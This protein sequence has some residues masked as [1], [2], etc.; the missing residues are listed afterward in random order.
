MK[1]MTRGLVILLALPLLSACH[2]AK[3]STV[4]EKRSYTNR[5][6]SEALRD[7]YKAD[8]GTRARITRAA[9]YAVID[10]IES[11][12]FLVGTGRGYGVA[13]NN[14]TGRRTYMRKGSLGAG[15]GMG[16]KNIR[17]VYVFHTEKALGDFIERGL[18]VGAG[19]DVTA[20]AKGKGLSA[21]GQAGLGAGGAS[22]GLGGEAGSGN[23]GGSGAGS[24]GMGVDT[25]VLTQWGAV[26][27]ANVMGTKYWKDKK[28]NR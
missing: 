5:M 4:A 18:K 12:I 9:G 3:G 7:L 19:A 20:K 22:V 28:L 8:P 1:A 25:Y 17:T 11:G 21:G 15:I 6:A 14:R 23:S 27:R 26:A 16:V 10:S 13:V 24:V 2:T